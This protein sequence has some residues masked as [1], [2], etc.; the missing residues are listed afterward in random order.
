MVSVRDMRQR[1]SD[2]ADIA[3]WA[4][5]RVP[6]MLREDDPDGSVSASLATPLRHLPREDPATEAERGDGTR[7][8][9]ADVGVALLRGQQV[10]GRP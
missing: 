6:K 10:L 1:Q 8:P 3:V 9:F 5:G 7:R 4:P 2:D